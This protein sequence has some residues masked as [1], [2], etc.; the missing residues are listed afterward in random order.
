MIAVGDTI[1]GALPIKDATHCKRLN[2]YFPSRLNEEFPSR[3]RIDRIL[4]TRPLSSPA[5]GCLFVIFA[6]VGRALVK[7]LACVIFSASWGMAGRA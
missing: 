7:G 6:Y 4:T 3:I 1:D 2:Q 5:R